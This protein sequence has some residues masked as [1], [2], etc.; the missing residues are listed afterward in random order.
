MKQEEE[1]IVV[2]KLYTYYKYVLSLK[3]LICF[4]SRQ[5]SL[6]FKKC[7]GFN[8]QCHLRNAFIWKETG[9]NKD[10]NGSAETGPGCPDSTF[11]PDRVAQ[12]TQH[13]GC[14]LIVQWH[15]I[16]DLWPHFGNFSGFI[17]WESL[18]ISAEPDR[19]FS[20]SFWLSPTAGPSTSPLGSSSCQKVRKAWRQLY[21]FFSKLL[22]LI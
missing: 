22:F 17:F 10:W 15:L 16:Q 6:A 7:N 1:L 5:F 13:P 3:W 21:P 4:F 2:R 9:L 8:C 20:Q 14:C 12:K 11:L 19:F 18:C